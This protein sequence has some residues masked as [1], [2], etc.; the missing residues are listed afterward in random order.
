M[1]KFFEESELILNAE[2]AIY[3]LGC[4]PGEIAENIIVVGDPKRVNTVSKYFDTIDFKMENRE[5]V[6]H[7]GTLNGKRI[8]ALSTGMG[9]DNIDI[10][11]N[12]LDALFNIDL[13]ERC[14]KDNLTSLN[15]VRLGTSGSLQPDIPIDSFCMATHGL[16]IDGVLNFYETPKGF[17]DDDLTNA[18]IEHTNW[19]AD[20][21]RPYIVKGSEKLAKQ[22]GEGFYSG[23]T[24]TAAGFFGPQGRELRLKLA[25][26][27]F[28]SL[29]ESFNHKGTKISNF[30]ME[31]SALYGLGGMMGHNMLTVCVIIANRIKREYS[32]DYKPLMETLVQTVLQRL[33]A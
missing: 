18:F 31:T 16:G 20:L 15:I 27:Q 10:V 9:P 23:I 32:K 1:K 7:T 29:F 17:I 3:H 24:A 13:K 25:Y 33:T 30:E 4:K 14:A 19:P 2:G 21:A 5:L 6:T 28:N 8:T 22:I 12:E 11:I 26:P